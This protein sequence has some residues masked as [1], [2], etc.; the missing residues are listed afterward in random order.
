MF[1]YVNDENYM[2]RLVKKFNFANRAI[3]DEQT[4]LV[5]MRKRSIVMNTLFPVAVVILELLKTIMYD[6][7]Y[8]ILRGHFGAQN[9]SCLGGDTD[10]AWIHILKRKTFMTI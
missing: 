4:C 1:F 7:Y 6:F 8:V 2:N 5:E 10:S 3:L 9:L